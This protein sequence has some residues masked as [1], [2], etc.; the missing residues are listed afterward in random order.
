MAGEAPK[1]TPPARTGGL[2]RL[3]AQA[4]RS[5][6]DRMSVTTAVAGAQA[7]NL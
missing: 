5:G 4:L 2:F 1:K 3:R 7:I 6:R